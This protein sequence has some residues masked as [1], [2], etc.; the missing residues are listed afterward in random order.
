MKL[1]SL[2]RSKG[3]Q[4]RA[5][6]FRVKASEILSRSD[7]RDMYFRMPDVMAVLYDSNTNL[8]KAEDYYKKARENYLDQNKIDSYNHV[9]GL[10]QT[11]N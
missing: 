6:E 5:W 3:E 9:V 11:L 7:K 1:Y 8:D 4:G 10:E 2:Y